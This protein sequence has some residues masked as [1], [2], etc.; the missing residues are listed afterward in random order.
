MENRLREARFMARM[1]QI[2]LWLA[3]GVHYSTI[4]RIECGY[5]TPTED[6]KEKMAKALNVEKDWLF[7]IPK[8][9]LS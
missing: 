2:R 4:S 8:K 1:P 7:P 3:T 6:Q 9:E 5:I